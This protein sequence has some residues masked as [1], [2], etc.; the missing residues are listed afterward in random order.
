[1]MDDDIRST[2]QM[3]ADAYALDDE[4][5]ADYERWESARVKKQQ[6][7]RGPVCETFGVR[8]RNRC[9]SRRRHDGRCN[10]GEMESMVR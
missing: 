2:R 9:S 6:D 10:R 8:N 1:M 7:N 4:T 5:R 3:L